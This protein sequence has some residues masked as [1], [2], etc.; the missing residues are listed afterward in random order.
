LTTEKI[1]LT[2]AQTGFLQSHI[3]HYCN[4]QW[5]VHC[6][7]YAGSDRRFVRVDN[8]QNADE[9]YILI[10]WNSQDNDWDR[11]IGI[12]RDLG[13]TVSFLPKIFAHDA[14]LGLILEE[15]LGRTTL[16]TY[17]RETD[18]KLSSIEKKYR[19]VLDALVAWQT[20]DV[21]RCNTISSRAMD[22][23]MY[24]WESEYFSTH[25]VTEFFGLESLLDEE[26]EQARKRIALKTS[27]LPRV[28]I[29]RDFQSENIML[30][31]VSIRFV[32]Y[33]GAR[34]GAP[35]YD[36]ASLIYDPYITELTDQSRRDLLDYYRTIAPIEVD[37]YAFRLCTVQRLMQALGAYG[38]LAIHKGK[39]WY[40]AYIPVALER[41]ALVVGQ[42]SQFPILENIV[43]CCR[44]QL[45]T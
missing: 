37:D 14:S 4:T 3:D 17:C 6:A 29:H 42:D 18:Q 2:P 7:G 35:G 1:V 5:D 21:V 38:N 26:W 15:D 27:G 19:Q 11:F 41:L 16:H 43:S 28:C 25:C 36:V 33:Q 22:L 30:Q 8:L 39:K 24:L 32:D 45:S 40:R 23:A 20:I 12:E 9:T 31:P 13:N 44:K 34:M 10:I